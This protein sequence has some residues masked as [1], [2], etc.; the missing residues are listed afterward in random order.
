MSAAQSDGF[1]G[2]FEPF[3]FKTLKA[4]PVTV[5][6][7]SVCPEGMEAFESRITQF[8]QLL[9][10]HKSRIAGVLIE[11]LIQGASGM[12]I[13]PVEFLQEIATLCKENS[14]P[15]IL[16]E[17]FTGMARCGDYFA[18][19]R[20]EIEP[21]IV[22]L[23][24]GLTGGAIPMAVTMATEEVFENFLFP[25]KDKA[26][27]HGH[28]YTGSAIGCAAA[29]ATLNLYKKLNLVDSARQLETRF[30]A[31]LEQ[32]ENRFGIQNRR[33]MGG[34]MAFE[35]PSTGEASYF[36]PAGETFT[37]LCFERGLFARPL[38]NTIYLVP[39]L[40]I[41]ESELDFALGVLS[42]SLAIFENSI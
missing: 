14:I 30:N 28:T 39:P 20:A 36:N 5:H 23:A 1:H 32:A 26:L 2:M 25:E 13:Q 15:L 10:D 33:A 4:S 27:L 19:Q 16:Y 11:P 18:F 8:K 34:V 38:G 40:T 42:E 6:K 22:C 35:L 17:V 7:S 3:M 24:K 21:D 9:V 12:N 31:W 37:K 29:L 41:G